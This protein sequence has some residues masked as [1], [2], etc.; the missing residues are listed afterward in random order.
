[1]NFK[2]GD[3]VWDI[4]NKSF[5]I[6]KKLSEEHSM[7]TLAVIERDNEKHHYPISLLKK[8]ADDTFKELK[9]EKYEL[10]FWY[11]LIKV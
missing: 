9:Y 4:A 7:D 1:M 5:V 6:F 3:R 11:N 10:I 8:T 2:V